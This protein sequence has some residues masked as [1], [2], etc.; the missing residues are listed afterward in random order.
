MKNF[1]ADQRAHSQ[2]VNDQAALQSLHEQLKN[3]Y[4]NVLQERESLEKSPREAK[5]AM[6]KLQ[7]TS[8]NVDMENSSVNISKETAVMNENDSPQILS[9]EHAK[10]KVRKL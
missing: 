2:L 9:V 6:G 7:E 1:L 4:E 8:T 10:L 3:E 5:T